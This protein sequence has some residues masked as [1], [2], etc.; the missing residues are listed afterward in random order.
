VEEVSASASSLE[1]MAQAL[2]DVVST[3]KLS[4]QDAS[5]NVNPT[6]AAAGS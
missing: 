5:Y 3:F 6:R 2:Q 4:Q 1:E